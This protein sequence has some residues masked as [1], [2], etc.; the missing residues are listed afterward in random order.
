MI[1]NEPAFPEIE[2]ING[3]GDKRFHVGMTIRQEFVKAAMQGILSRHGLSQDGNY[4]I[5]A[6]DAVV[7]A[8]ACLKAEMETRK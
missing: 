4:K 2:V 6:G 5:I 8:D 3:N 1:G 7:A